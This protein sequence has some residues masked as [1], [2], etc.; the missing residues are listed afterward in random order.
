MH[1]CQPYSYHCC[2][3]LLKLLS[4]D[5]PNSGACL[6]IVAHSYAATDC[7]LQVLLSQ[8]ER[9]GWPSVWFANPIPSCDRRSDQAHVRHRVK[10]EH[11]SDEA[12]MCIPP[13][14]ARW[15]R[16]ERSTN[17]NNGLWSLGLR[18][19]PGPQDM[20]DTTPAQCITFARDPEDTIP[21]ASRQDLP[22]H[23]AAERCKHPALR[24]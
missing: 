5:P 22:H 10:A 1:N 21:Q 16:L 14:Q 24:P 19:L 6:C 18:R 8:L 2:V 12:N 4:V 17:S 9:E 13:G 15:T 20:V 23:H 11:Y 7:C 3:P